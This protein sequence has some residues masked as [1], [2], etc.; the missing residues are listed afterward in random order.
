MMHPAC[1]LPQ[2]TLAS[3]LQWHLVRF[4]AEGFLCGCHSTFPGVSESVVT[5][6]KHLPNTRLFVQMLSLNPHI[7]PIKKV[8]L[9]LFCS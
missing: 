6:V 8:L 2:P 3:V 9:S 1:D 4:S 5:F 7:H